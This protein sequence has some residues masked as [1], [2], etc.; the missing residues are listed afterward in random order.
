MY[1]TVFAS[2]TPKK[3]KKTKAAQVENTPGGGAA[4]GGGGDAGPDARLFVL[5][6]TALMLAAGAGGLVLRARRR[7]VRQ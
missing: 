6:G 3:T 1:E 2:P 7:P 4:T 5:T